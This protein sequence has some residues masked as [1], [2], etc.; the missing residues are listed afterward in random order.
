M[1]SPL[2]SN[3]LSKPDAARVLLLTV[4]LVTGTVD[5]T[6]GVSI[7]GIT[8]LGAFT[9]AGCGA[10]WAFWI[11]RP[12]LPMDLLKP[13]L[14]LVLFELYA[15]GSMSWYSPGPKGLQLLAVG[16]AFLGLILL[17]ARETDRD[18]A[19][20]D[21]LHKVL[22]ITS[23]PAVLLYFYA[24]EDGGLA[25]DGLVNARPF[26]LYAMVALAVAVARWR[27]GG[28]EGMGYL[29][30]GGVIVLAVFLSLSR[31]ALVACLLLFPIGIALRLN[32]KS[33]IQ[34][35]VILVIATTAF[36]TAVFTYQPLYER[37]FGYD[38][39]TM[40]G[41]DINVSGRAKMW[42]MLFETLGNDWVFGKGI[43]A[44]G[45][46]IDEYFPD[47]GHPHN[48]F[49]RFYYDLGVVGLSMWLTFVFAFTWKTLRNL[50]RSIRDAG[51]DYPVHMAALMALI[52]VSGSMFTD[53]SVSYS[54]VMMPLAI[55]MGCSLGAGRAA[56][57]SAA[58]RMASVSE[59]IGP[60]EEEVPAHRRPRWGSSN[61]TLIDS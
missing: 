33:L 42:N 24:V 29:V 52:A 32:R 50:R 20:A 46:L 39:A 51:G 19:L 18:A 13:L 10:A 26:A 27:A 45:N 57:R 2:S 7:G 43:A 60:V 59:V 31:T 30:W 53:N 36:V 38:M 1:K 3:L 49:L 8:A 48:D 14:P 44:S 12:Y 55:V 17:T 41:V 47:I 35:V 5:F 11:T 34:A 61:P 28:R 21:D 58:A 25:A 23:V 6:R 56:E 15:V 16:L 40:G 4:L 9:L 54:F 22:L 37:F